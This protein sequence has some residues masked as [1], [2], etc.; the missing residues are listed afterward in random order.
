ME[1]SSSRRC[2]VIGILLISRSVVVSFEVIQHTVG[3]RAISESWIEAID[4]NVTMSGSG[5]LGDSF[6]VEPSTQRDLGGKQ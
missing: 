3:R 1:Y 2:L 6:T 5:E 4:E